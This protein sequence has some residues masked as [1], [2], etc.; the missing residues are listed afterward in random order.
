MEKNSEANYRISFFKRIFQHKEK[1]NISFAS[2][3]IKEMEQFYLML[4]KL[5]QKH[6]HFSAKRVVK[7]VYPNFFKIKHNKY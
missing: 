5:E 3:E 2:P 6:I 1:R 7:K 4:L